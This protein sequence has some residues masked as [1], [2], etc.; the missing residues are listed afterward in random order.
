[1]EESKLTMEQLEEISK[2]LDNNRP[3]EV[4]R[5]EE[6][7]AESKLSEEIETKLFYTNVT[8]N[9]DTGLAELSPVKENTAPSLTDVLEGNAD[10]QDTIKMNDQ[11]QKDIETLF[12]IED[13][14]E[15]LLIMD[16]LKRGKKGEKIKYEELPRSLKTMASMMAQVSNKQEATRDI[17]KFALNNISFEQASADFNDMLQKEMQ[18]IPEVIEMYG[19]SLKDK[20]ENE[21]KERAEKEENPKIKENLLAVSRE[22]TESYTFNRIFE[23]IEN[24]K[25]FVRK[26]KKEIKRY[27]R[28]VTDFNYKYNTSKFSQHNIE[29]IVNPMYRALK[30]EIDIDDA[31]KV[32]VLISKV[33]QNMT[34]DKVEEH[35]YMYYIVEHF[36]ALDHIKEGKDNFLS[37]FKVNIVKLVNKI[38]EI[39][40]EK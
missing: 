20:F 34:P 8:I 9:N 17:I 38:H 21:Y 6:A 18:S 5:L 24:N 1:M 33:C 19:D 15:A 39:E 30:T 37:D 3:E 29:L 28:W 13:E 31:L 36:L 14:S 40:N 32:L 11:T 23:F 12:N 27:H 10:L 16:I 7:Q 35:A 4:K 2:S 22:F 26:L 25:S